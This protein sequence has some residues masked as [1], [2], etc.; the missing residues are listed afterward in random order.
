MTRRRLGMAGFAA[1]AAAILAGSMNKSTGSSLDLERR[2][3]EEND[4]CQPGPSD[5]WNGK[6]VDPHELKM[7]KQDQ[8]RF[9]NKQQAR[10]NM[11]GRK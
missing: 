2:K 4:A 10:Y 11:K 8:K 6:A 5:Y 3:R 1:A 9:Q 7:R